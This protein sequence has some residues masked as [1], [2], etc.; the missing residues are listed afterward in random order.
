MSSIRC[1]SSPRST[2]G[3]VE[4]ETADPEEAYEGL[5]V[6]D[7]AYKDGWLPGSLARRKRGV[8]GLG[9]EARAVLGR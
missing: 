8:D 3:S 5:T 6:E 9:P 2:A 4:N 7:T 1:P